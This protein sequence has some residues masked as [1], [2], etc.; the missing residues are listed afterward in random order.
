[1]SLGLLVG[2]TAESVQEIYLDFFFNALKIP[3]LPGAHIS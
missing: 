2:S 3:S 1:M